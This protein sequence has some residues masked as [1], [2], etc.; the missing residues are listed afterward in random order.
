M[1]RMFRDLPTFYETRK[2]DFA[3]QFWPQTRFSPWRHCDLISIALM[4]NSRTVGAGESGRTEIFIVCREK[5][6]WWDTGSGSG[7]GG[8]ECV[9][10]DTGYIGQELALRDTQRPGPR[11]SDGIRVSGCGDAGP[12]SLAAHTDIHR[13]PEGGQW[14]LS[15]DCHQ[16]SIQ[17]NNI[18]PWRQALKSH[19]AEASVKRNRKFSRAN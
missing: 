6:G 13:A 3:I 8:C 4:Q 10:G 9:E 15:A 17:G 14:P 2:S 7:S 12:G 19:L 16:H 5:A 11:S 1:S 18:C